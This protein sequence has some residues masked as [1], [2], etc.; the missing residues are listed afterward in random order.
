[1]DMTLDM[2]FNCSIVVTGRL[3]GINAPEMRGPEKPEG[4]RSRDWLRREIETAK[5]VYV[6]TRPTTEKALGKYGRWL[7]T[8][9]ADGVNLNEQLVEKGLAKHASY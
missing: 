1:M 5:R 7:V 3:Y 4:I 9:Y 8:I 6:Q 2:G